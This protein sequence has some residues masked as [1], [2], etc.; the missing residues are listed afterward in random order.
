MGRTYHEEADNTMPGMIPILRYRVRREVRARRR[1]RQR[2]T[3]P[4]A[5][6]VRADRYMPAA[7]AVPAA[8]T[9]HERHPAPAG[10]LAAAAAEP[11]P[12]RYTS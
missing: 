9:Q 10:F 3:V 6:T 5:V 2:N 11:L 7:M 1:N 12:D 8:G 4:A